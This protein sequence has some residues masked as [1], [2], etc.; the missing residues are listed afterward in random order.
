MIRVII[1][2]NFE[3]KLYEPQLRKL[4]EENKYKITDTN[5][6]DF[7]IRKT[8]YYCFISGREIIGAIYFFADGDKLFLNAYGPRG[9]FEEKIECLKLSLSWFRCDIY[10]EAQN[11]A[12][13]LCLLRAG[14]RRKEGKLF[15]YEH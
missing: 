4:Y 12:S 8:F 10:A 3:F 14:F 2:S 15:R 1:P 11:R 13:A 6:F 5:T 7:I 9:H